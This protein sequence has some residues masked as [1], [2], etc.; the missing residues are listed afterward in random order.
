MKRIF[1]LTAG[2]MALLFAAVVV[3]ACD[4][5]E[6]AK[7]EEQIPNSIAPINLKYTPE[8]PKVGKEGG[9]VRIKLLWEYP[10]I[11]PMTLSEKER[12]LYYNWDF[13]IC[14]IAYYYKNGN[15]A[16]ARDYKP[17]AMGENKV[18]YEG[19]EGLIAEKETE[20]D[21]VYL[22]VTVP[23][24]DNSKRRS[25]RV[26]IQKGDESV[27]PWMGSAITIQQD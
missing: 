11:N 4:N 3:S 5:D 16:E 20:G 12:E 8:V 21:Y 26:D 15:E 25:F 14:Y 7:E 23:R 19:F 2:L 1:K 17:I 18:S 9:S 13:S 24:N 27:Y 6:P 22:N 10:E